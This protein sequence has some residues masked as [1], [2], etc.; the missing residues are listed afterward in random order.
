M[1]TR[2]STIKKMQIEKSTSEGKKA[3]T[4]EILKCACSN[5]GCQAIFIESSALLNHLE[6]ECPYFESNASLKYKKTVNESE[7]GRSNLARLLINLA[8]S[9]PG[10]ESWDKSF[11]PEKIMTN[12]S[13]Q[14]KKPD[15]FPRATVFK[16]IDPIRELDEPEIELGQVPMKSYL[17]CCF[18]STKSK[19]AKTFIAYRMSSWFNIYIKEIYGYI[20]K[21]IEGHKDKTIS[22]KLNSLKM[23][24]NKI[25]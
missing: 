5:K 7:I 8:P 2:K 1:K 3:F 4:Q 11:N 14:T 20:N 6:Y 17:C 13:V 10:L 12:Y 18:T 23:K 15:R 16:K 21:K 19:I 24:E 25:T 22:L 9:T